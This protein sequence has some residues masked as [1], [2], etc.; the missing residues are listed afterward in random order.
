MKKTN[1]PQSGFGILAI[2][3]I[4]AIVAAIGTGGYYAAKSSNQSKV[5]TEREQ[6]T[7][8]SEN[9]VQGTTT[10]SVSVRNLL[11]LG[12]SLS[13]SFTRAD[14]SNTTSGTVYISGA[15]GHLRGDFTTTLKSGNT[16]ESHMIQ[17]DNK[18]YLW[19]SAQGKQGI[20]MNMSG[21]PSMMQSTTSAQSSVNID[22]ALDYRCS[23]WTA[24]ASRFK[25][26]STVI[27]T[28]FSAMMKV[29]L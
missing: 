13:C 20:V 25:T 27:F 11:G 21:G 22:E 14:G 19:S 17:K 12:K 26:P 16:V 15:D 7:T 3:I 10:T 28:D 6:D 8:S 1:M 23:D 24:D 4:V 29:G 9:S 5:R 18:S 2:V